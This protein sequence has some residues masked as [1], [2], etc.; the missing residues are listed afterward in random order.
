M[1]FEDDEYWEDEYSEYSLMPNTAVVQERHFAKRTEPDPVIPTRRPRSGDSRPGDPRSDDPRPRDPRLGDPRL[2][3]SGPVDELAA[4]RERR[5]TG[6]GAPP[7]PQ[8]P[9][10]AFDSQRPS[11]LNDPDFVPIDT[12]VPNLAGSELDGIDF[13]RPELGADFDA[14]EFSITGRPRRDER[15]GNYRDDIDEPYDHRAGPGGRANTVAGTGGGRTDDGYADRSRQPDDRRGRGPGRPDDRRTDSPAAQRPGHGGDPRREW[16]PGQARTDQARTDQARTDQAGRRPGPVQP[17]PG[18]RHAEPAASGRARVPE[19]RPQDE[20]RY[21]RPGRDGR[22]LPGG[23]PTG[24][25]ED[26]AALDRRSRRPLNPDSST[27]RYPDEILRRPA[28]GWA[29][30]AD[31]PGSARPV[32]PRTVDPRTPDP[33]TVDPRTLDPRGIDPRSLGEPAGRSRRGARAQEFGPDDLIGADNGAAERRAQRPA[34]RAE[35]NPENGPRVISKATPPGPPRVIGKEAPTPVPRV[36]K[37]AE[38]AVPPKVVG[39]PTSAPAPR[40]AGQPA[41]ASGAPTVPL[42]VSPATAPPAVPAARGPA[43]ADRSRPSAPQAAR[44][45]LAQPAPPRSGAVSPQGRA[46]VV[47]RGAPVQQP[48]VDPAARHGGSAETDPRAAAPYPPD[49]AAGYNAPPEP[50]RPRRSPRTAHVILS[51]SDGPWSMVPDD[52]PPAALPIGG[53]NRPASP[54]APY[55]GAPVPPAATPPAG[56]PPVSAPA[57]GTSAPPAAL[58]PRWAPPAALPPVSAPAAATPS[59][60]APPVATPPVSAPPAATRSVSGPPVSAS[61]ASASPVSAP[62]V[63]VPPAQTSARPAQPPAAW[64]PPAPVPPGTV[65]PA[66]STSAPA[67]PVRP[68]ATSPASVPPV[69]TETPTARPGSLGDVAAGSARPAPWTPD[70]P[71]TMRPASPS[72]DGPGTTRAVTPGSGVASDEPTGPASH[73]SSPS[74]A[75]V[76]A[77]AAGG[78]RTGGPTPGASTTAGPADEPGTSRPAA[79]GPDTSRP[80]ASGPGTNGPGASGPDTSRPGA[81]ELGVPAADRVEEP[82]RSRADAAT[83]QYAAMRPAASDSPAAG[84]SQPESP[85]VVTA[86]P[87]AE[88]VDT[89]ASGSPR[90]ARAEP[91]AGTDETA[92][93]GGSSSAAGREQMG[94]HAAPY[95]DPDGTLHNLRPI[96]RLAVSG[97][98]PQPR[99]PADTDFGGLWFAAPKENDDD[100]PGPPAPGT[101]TGTDTDTDN[102]ENRPAEQTTP[103]PEAAAD[104]AKDPRG[105]H[106]DGTTAQVVLDFDV[107]GLFSGTASPDEP[108][109]VP[110]STAGGADAAEPPDSPV[111]P[112]GPAPEQEKAASAA[113]D[114]AGS[115]GQPASGSTG[116]PGSGSP[117]Q[118]GSGSPGQPASR[119]PGPAEA[120][121]PQAQPAPDPQSAPQTPD[122][123]RRAAVSFMPPPEPAAAPPQ[124]ETERWTLSAADLEAIRWR[125]DGGTLREVVD[126]RGALRELGERLDGPLAD[127]VDNV[128][129]AGLLSVRAE[130][131]RLLG[132][133]GMAAAASRLALAHAESAQHV[134]SVV[135]AQAELAH[136]LRL[137]RDYVEAD[138]LFAKAIGAPVPE[139]LR[140]V[141]HENAGRSCFDQGRQMEAL[142]H[143]ARAVRLGHPDD[144]DLA[145]RVGVCLEAVYIHVLRDG[146]GPYP[147]STADI[148]GVPGPARPEHPAQPASFGERV[149]DLFDEPTAEQP[150]VRY[151]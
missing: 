106:Q 55:P 9:Q 146:W 14:P 88:S 70:G 131:Y 42:P 63:S 21:P 69:A 78:G 25:A 92:K 143:F 126:D 144:V 138:R 135:I 150:I 95:M 94:A 8:G 83:W 96:A 23:R 33:R 66:A 46:Q 19:A 38:P 111:R 121:R 133:L 77:P 26:P 15:F 149:P 112:D 32:D 62:P 56:R 129:K 101:G 90:E 43:P 151:R 128:A 48:R 134:Q 119:T 61:P 118:P 91:A 93:P 45:P 122:A 76:S 72:P 86:T 49:G 22:A 60:S 53:L 3:D 109:V 97:P 40:P 17:R 1:S 30:P 44:P 39:T 2:G 80:A 57:A 116:Q 98:D 58:P 47:S 35:E 52:A 125:L 148:L 104:T 11:W 142:D 89:A 10:V 99:R 123:Q 103:T 64:T 127:E 124:A 28:E 105:D 65:A 71:G 54:D 100:A 82:T 145:E 79:S 113:A 34:P 137:R 81:N 74:S 20:D 18:E 115:T 120:S 73:P 68:A 108:A 36:V 140:S 102:T 147:R 85:I 5:A 13:N 114:Q 117:G 110:P 41:A 84:P 16:Q 51:E 75:P 12:S 31:G 136:V 4:R 130:V 37:K 27:G 50:P 24:A 141:V 132:E 67:T 6:H 87:A 107:S 139:T 7:G 59:V 29:Y